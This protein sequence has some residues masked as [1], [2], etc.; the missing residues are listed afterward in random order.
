MNAKIKKLNNFLLEKQQKIFFYMAVSIFALI[1]LYVYFLFSS[2][3]YTY[4]KEKKENEL[5]NLVL[6]N[7]E[8]KN[9]LIR[10]ELKVKD[11]ELSN[12]F[13]KI[14]NIEYLRKSAPVVAALSR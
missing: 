6:N 5:A 9:T 3:S 1:I 2:V 8:T 4:A 7:I 10:N 11:T 12:N 13:V 14:K